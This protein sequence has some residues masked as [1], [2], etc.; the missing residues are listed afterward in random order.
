ML[1]GLKKK[2]ISFI[3]IIFPV[4]Y[5]LYCIILFV[6]N[7]LLITSPIFLKNHK[8]LN[9]LFYIH[10]SL[11]TFNIMIYFILSIITLIYLL[12]KLNILNRILIIISIYGLFISNISLVTGIFWGYFSWGQWIIF[13]NKTYLLLIIS[14]IYIL[15]YF[16]LSN[17]YTLNI[18]I[19]PIILLIS[20]P[21]WKMLSSWWTTLH[22][23]FSV[24]FIGISFPSN[25][26]LY[27]FILFLSIIISLIITLLIEI[28]SYLIKY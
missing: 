10:S 13:D 15:T 4:T 9:I 17:I 19:L 6:L 1:V 8:E 14:F 2:I 16:I 28:Y 22:Q 25:L 21:F 24:S 7:N 23:S 11:S 18:N 12:T 27:F 5:L 20:L 3:Y 26:L